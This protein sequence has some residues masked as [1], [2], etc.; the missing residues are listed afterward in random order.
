MADTRTQIAAAMFKPV[1]GGYVFR[2]PYRW[3]FSQSPHYL[4]NE[5]QKDQLLTMTVP[6]RPILWH[7]ALWGTLC[8]MV[9]VAGIVVWAYTRHAN[10]T[11]IDTISMMAL[12]FAQVV[13]ALLENRHCNRGAR[14]V[15]E[16]RRPSGSQAPYR[17]PTGRSRLNRSVTM[18]IRSTLFNASS[19]MRS[20]TLAP[21]T[22]YGRT[23]RQ[24]EDSRCMTLPRFG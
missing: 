1:L 3:P 9:A 6:K 22:K 23:K 8:L 10:P 12:T 16:P 21:I 5:A 2:E 24:C 4:V 11:L 14:G 18:M 15:F 17:V 7:I 19:S 20:R 13:V